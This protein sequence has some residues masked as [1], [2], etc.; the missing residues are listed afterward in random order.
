MER[1]K[2]NGGRTDLL[3]AAVQIW[4]RR[5]SFAPQQGGV[6]FGSDGKNHC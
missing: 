5:E 2:A 3:D 1:D 6:A 4:G